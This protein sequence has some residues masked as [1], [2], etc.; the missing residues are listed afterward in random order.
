LP[1]DLTHRRVD[2]LLLV[3]VHEGF[4]RLRVVGLS[5]T[6]KLTN[7]LLDRL[8]GSAEPWLLRGLSGLLCG[9]E[10]GVHAA[11]QA[12][13]VGSGHGGLSRL[14]ACGLCLLE[15]R[16]CSGHPRLIGGGERGHDALVESRLL[17]RLSALRSALEG[18]VHA[19]GKARLACSSSALR[20]ATKQSIHTLLE[21][22]LS[23]RLGGHANRL[24]ALL[25]R[26]RKARLLGRL[27]GHARS[28]GRAAA[29]ASQACLCSSEVAGAGSRANTAS[30]VEVSAL[31][32]EPWLL[33]REGSLLGRE[34]AL[35]Q[36]AHGDA[37]RTGEVRL[38]AGRH[39][40]GLAQESLRAAEVRAG[41][42]RRHALRFGQAREPLSD[43]RRRRTQ[44]RLAGERGHVLSRGQRAKARVDVLE[45]RIEAGGRVRS[46]GPLASSL[47]I[48]KTL[49]N[50][51]QA[52][53][54][55]GGRATSLLHRSLGI[56]EL[57]AGVRTAQ[58]ISGL[59]GGPV[60]SAKRLIGSGH[61]GRE[62]PDTLLFSGL[63]RG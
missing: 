44:V 48:A 58:N 17:G 42:H 21:P 46:K 5:R 51:L 4:S 34:R 63:D 38:C 29:C 37:L 62:G 36:S 6:A 30:H 31:G 41:A 26:L 22:R 25:Q 43:S 49:L 32:R 35:L 14:H 1:L 12:R 24:L 7:A 53:R 8:L 54:D 55:A 56:S 16:L 59:S 33:G 45:C 47:Q 28:L 18:G 40:S 19:L 11:L 60:G 61:V 20:S 57:V 15:T 10:L 3:G 52:L 9:S 50:W 2:H 23:S 27:S 39:A 13:L